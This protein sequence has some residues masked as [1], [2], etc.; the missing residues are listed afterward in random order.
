MILVPPQVVGFELV[1]KSTGYVDLQTLLL[2]GQQPLWKSLRTILWVTVCS[3]RKSECPRPPSM[4]LLWRFQFWLVYHW[5][6]TLL[7]LAFM[8]A[9]FLNDWW[10]VWNWR[11]IV[12]KF[13]MK[14]NWKWWWFNNKNQYAI[15]S[16]VGCVWLVRFWKLNHFKCNASI[17]QCVF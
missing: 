3:E 16:R 17:V 12:P 13:S 15:F 11:N 7:M 14:S 1:N 4:Y 8:I 10:F 5:G 2:E 6:R 9:I